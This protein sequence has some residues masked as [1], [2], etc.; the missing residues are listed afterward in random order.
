MAEAE[1]TIPQEPETIPQEPAT[2]PPEPETIPQTITPEPKRGRGR[3]A[4]AKDKAPR[5]KKPRVRV[6]PIP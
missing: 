5:E 3:P 6:E 4:G 2:I 1:A